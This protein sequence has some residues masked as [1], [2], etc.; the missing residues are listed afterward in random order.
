MNTT[1]EYII[2]KYN[3]NSTSDSPIFLPDTRKNL[4]KLFNELGYKTGAE[5][6]VLEGEFSKIF[7]EDIPGVTLYCIDP[8]E[9]YEDLPENEKGGNNRGRINRGY[10]RTKS[11]LGAYS[12]NIV[13]KYSM[14]AVKDFTRG[15]LDFVYI[16]ANHTFDYVMRDI[17][18]WSKIVRPGGIVSG[19]D[20][21]AYHHEEIGYQVRSAIDVYTNVHNIKLIFVFN[22]D[23]CTSWFFVKN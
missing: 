1:V 14:D 4:P 23:Y 10:E 13:K 21:Q 17:I 18:E 12:C 5:I 9:I 8:W 7:C 16:D 2:K 3:I 11:L 22:G 19:H 20:Y 6:G 15:S